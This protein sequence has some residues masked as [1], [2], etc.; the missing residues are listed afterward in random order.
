MENI[1]ILKGDRKVRYRS[2]EIDMLPKEFQ[3][4]LF[5]YERQ[6]QV[7]TRGELLDAVWAMEAPTDRTVDDHIYRLRK[8]LSSLSSVLTIE[9]VRGQGYRLK[10]DK[11]GHSSPLLH[12]DEVSS[13]VKTLFHKYH[14][15]GQGDA[16]KLL[17][18]NQAVF[19]FELDLQSKLYLRFM[20]GE[21]ESF[22][23]TDEE[24]FWEKCYYLLHLYSYITSDKK[25]SLAYFT[26][27]LDAKEMPEHHR[28]E[29]RLLNRLS[30]L[31]L[32][33]QLDEAE[34]LLLDSKKEVNDRKLEGFIPLLFLTEIYLA[35][36]KRDPSVIQKKVDE[37]E[38]LLLQYP[39]SR[40]RASFSIIKGVQCLTER[41]GEK[42]EEHFD[43]GIYLF[44]E[45]QYVPGILIS[46]MTIVFFSNEFQCD[47]LAKRYD[48]LWERYAEEYKLSYLEGKIESLLEFYLN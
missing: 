28:L 45:A 46:L 14:L 27:A 44:K 12:D 32:T 18:E 47:T 3:L 37:M 25:K 2:E 22:L 21:F 38:N 7:F 1:Q 10:V 19:G 16:L 34:R 29:I 23:D 41:K 9:T 8:K 48:H 36:L 31:I 15:Y 42:A 11:N 17:E 33:K 20:K 5:L 39:F 6:A 4:F 24:P 30:L 43:Q 35:F 26:K 40:E 13:N